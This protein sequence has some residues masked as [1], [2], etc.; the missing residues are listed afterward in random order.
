[1]SDIKAYAVAAGADEHVARLEKEI[2]LLICDLESGQRRFFPA[3]LPFNDALL[4]QEDPD[5]IVD[6]ICDHLAEV[7]VVAGCYASLAAAHR[8]LAVFKDIYLDHLSP[9]ALKTVYIGYTHQ[10]DVT[11]EY[12]RAVEAITDAAPIAFEERT[13]L[14]YFK[15]ID[16][17]DVLSEVV[18]ITVDISERP[19]VRRWAEQ[20]MERSQPTEE[21]EDL[22]RAL[23]GENIPFELFFPTARVYQVGRKLDN[24]LSSRDRLDVLALACKPASRQSFWLA[25]RVCQ[26]R[27]QSTTPSTANGRFCQGSP[28]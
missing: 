14:I 5:A 3:V 22:I 27:N 13:E 26:G 6:A 10:I 16:V 11:V 24:P 23:W 4:D 18:D 12:L 9:R 19:E 2:G 28:T 20:A 8:D 21:T 25:S 17:D 15:F 1:M 7:T